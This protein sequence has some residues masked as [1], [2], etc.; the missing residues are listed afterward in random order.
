MATIRILVAL[1]F[2]LSAQVYAASDNLSVPASESDGALYPL[3]LDMTTGNDGGTQFLSV[4]A[5]ILQSLKDS[6][7]GLKTDLES[8]WFSWSYNRGVGT[9]PDTCADGYDAGLGLCAQQCPQGYDSVLGVCWQ[10]CPQGFTDMGAVCASWAKWVA[11]DSFT[12]DLQV[13]TCADGMVNE[14]GLCYEPCADSFNGVGPLCIGQFDGSQGEALLNAQVSEQHDAA[15]QSASAGGIQLTDEQAPQLRTEVI[16]TPIMCTLDAFDGLFGVV[17]D[18]ASLA[19]MG[20]DAAGDAVISAISDAVPAGGASFIPSVADTVLFD[21]SAD[22]YCADDGVVATAGLNMDP[23]ITVQVSTRMFDPA[24]HNLAG[25]DLG[26]MQVSVYELIPFRIYGTVGTTLGAETTLT[27]VIDRSMP[28]LMVDGKQYSTQTALEVKPEMDLWLSSEAY[29]RV[30]SIFSFIPDLLQLGAEF[31]LHVLD[32]VMPYRVDE[33]LRQAES[34][35]ELYR[36]EQLRSE[37]SSGHGYVDTF[38]R[39]L[40]IETNAFGDE[41]DIEWQGHSQT[42]EIFDRETATPVSI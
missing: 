42:D 11:K 38:L 31:K 39:V 13:M 9:I 23:S 7:L 22:A 14:A 28:A 35:Y 12:Q 21:F 32:V 2:A 27:S 26:I 18:P 29:I 41:A 16:F 5:D 40:G 1:C 25:V 34:G 30:T 37:L 19:A 10:Q 17:P 8:T 36:Q 4:G 24:L 15:Q 20:V 6:A 33:G 3:Q